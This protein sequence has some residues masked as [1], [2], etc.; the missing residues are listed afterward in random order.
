[1]TDYVNFPR[2]V[3]RFLPKKGWKKCSSY[4]CYVTVNNKEMMNELERYDKLDVGQGSL[5]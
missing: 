1:M 4:F 2:Y 3:G 5:I